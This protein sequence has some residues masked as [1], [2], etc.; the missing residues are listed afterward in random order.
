MVLT[1]TKYVIN[2]QNMMASKTIMAVNVAHVFDINIPDGRPLKT[3]F[4]PFF[5][6]SCPPANRRRKLGN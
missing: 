4:W 2:T 1:V 6:L 5:V 3:Y